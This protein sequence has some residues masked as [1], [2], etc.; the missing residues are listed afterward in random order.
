VELGKSTLAHHI[1]VPKVL[2]DRE[3]HEVIKLADFGI[4]ALAFL[5]R[6]RLGFGME[7]NGDNQRGR[8]FGDFYGIL[9]GHCL[10]E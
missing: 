10:T 8:L 9:L 5:G 7:G 6:E 1:I 2:R 4:D 3:H